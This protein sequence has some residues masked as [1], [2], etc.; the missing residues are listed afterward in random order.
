[1][2]CGGKPVTRR[3]SLMEI[4]K[5]RSFFEIIFDSCSSGKNVL[6]GL[7]LLSL[8]ANRGPVFEGCYFLIPLQVGIETKRKIFID[9]LETELS[10]FDKA[11]AFHEFY[12]RNN[13]RVSFVETDVSQAYKFYFTIKAY[14]IIESNDLK[15]KVLGEGLKFIEKYYPERKNTFTYERLRDDYEVI[16]KQLLIAYKH[17][18][19]EFE[20]IQ[21]RLEFRDKQSGYDEAH[22]QIGFKNVEKLK[23]SRT[24]QKTLKALPESTNFVLQAIYT[25]VITSNILKNDEDFILFRTDKGEESIENFLLTKR[26]E[27]NKG[28]V[29]LIISEDVGARKKIQDI[30]R[31]SNNTIFVLSSYGL[32]VALKELG[33]I[34]NLNEIVDQSLLD[35]IASRKKDNK[36]RE[37][38][39]KVFTD[40]DVKEPEVEEKWAMRLVEVITRGYWRGASLNSANEKDKHFFSF[41]RSRFGKNHFDK[42]KKKYLTQNSEKPDFKE[43]IMKIQNL[44]SKKTELNIRQHK[45]E[46]QVIT[47]SSDETSCLEEVL[48][49]NQ[50]ICKKHQYHFSNR[51]YN[52]DYSSEHINFDQIF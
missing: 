12:R 16:K 33:L 17:F 49:E 41:N 43:Q 23:L 38:K 36:R 22:T 6:K 30:R 11:G 42:L 18:K 3:C 4:Y 34:E 47:K 21:R 5:K 37:R 50:K 28:I 19:K 9:F 51:F 46:N 26:R 25:S 2:G 52:P 27:T 15:E 45:I 13:K 10:N 7:E 35:N 14:K 44:L 32:A 48:S 40:Q 39:G 24:F 8:E 31:R 20:V 29:T 1:M